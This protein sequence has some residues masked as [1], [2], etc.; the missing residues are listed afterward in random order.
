MRETFQAAKLADVARHAGVGN[1]TASRALNGGSLVSDDTRK[2]ILEA[3]RTLNYL[4]NRSAQT[5]KGGRSGMIGMVI[6]RMSHMFFASSVE[7]VQAVAGRNASLLVVAATHDSSDRTMEAVKQLLRHQVDGLVLAL[8]EYL[9]PEMVRSLRSLPV[10]AVGIDAPLTKAKLPSV[11]INNAAMARSATEHLIA[12]GYKR[13]ISLQIN[14]KLYTMKER[15]HGYEQAMRDAGLT[16]KQ[17]VIESREK[18]EDLLRGHRVTPADYAFLAINEAAAKHLI[19]AAKKLG[20]TMPQDFGMISFDDFDVS[21][22]ME[23]PLTVIRQPVEKIGEAAANI[24]FQQLRDSD[25]AP[26]RRSGLETVI[27]AELVVRHSC[28]CK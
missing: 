9:T 13:I 15:R 8:S 3:A 11:L 23:T 2:R 20:M 10:P 28:G 26:S 17:H 25:G 21:D 14:P 6:P 16:P 4:P 18:A 7:A 24:L 27:S 19:A 1:A 12:H 22:V 5:L